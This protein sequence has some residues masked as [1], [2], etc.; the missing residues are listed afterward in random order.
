MSDGSVV[1]HLF[2]IAHFT[3]D[4]RTIS[5]P[6]ACAT[7]FAYMLLR[8]GAEVPRARLLN[9]VAGETGEAT[10]RRRLNTAVW[11]LRCALEPDGA[12]RTSVVA[13]TGQGIAIA[14][15]CHAWIDV[16]EFEG[17]CS[18]IPPVH[19]WRAEDAAA[20]RQ[21]IDLYGGP[22]LDGVYD[23]WVLEERSRLA[24]AHLSA[25]LRLAHWHDLHHEPEAAL[26]YAHIAVATDPLRE[27]LQALLIRL[28]RSAGLPEMAVHQFEA[29]RS[30]LKRELGVEPRLETRAAVTADA[31]DPASGTADD[32]N[33]TLHDALVELEHARNE[34][35]TI[36]RHLDVSI[37][38]LRS[39][40]QHASRGGEEIR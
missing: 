33:R 3:R 39:A 23:D 25:L 38:E 30:L 40:S 27:D 6:P 34:L 20:L 2:G 19:E 35:S 32:V 26:R 10:A 29:C 7:L 24:D 15:E 22:F 8:K 9:L 37:T 14:G 16:R 4:G 31:G 12:P 11:R 17:A 36:A 1:A 13:S 5:M 28:Y 18:S 21:A